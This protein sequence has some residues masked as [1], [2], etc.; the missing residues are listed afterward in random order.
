MRRKTIC[1]IIFLIISL[2]FVMCLISTRDIIVKMR[3]V[4]SGEEIIQDTES[5]WYPFSLKKK[6]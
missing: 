4:A 2:Y 1:L 3:S 6:S 5:L